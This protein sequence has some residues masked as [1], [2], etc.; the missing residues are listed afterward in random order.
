MKILNK[1]LGIYL[2]L[3]ALV[4]FSCVEEDGLVTP[5]VASPVLVLLQ[6]SS[7]QASA[8]VTVTGRFYELDKSGILDHRVGIDSIPV[9]GLQV[10]VFINHNQEIGSAT[11]DSNGSLV[12]QQPWS[13]LGLSSPRAGNSVRLEFAGVHKNIAFR[14]YHNVVVRQ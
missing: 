6:G 14:T 8:P 1:N 13:T 4:C 7:F 5:N 9:A 3:L 10:R 2:A 12:F 11:T